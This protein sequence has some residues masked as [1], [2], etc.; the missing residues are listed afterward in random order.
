MSAPRTLW[1]IS[2]ATLT[3]FLD[4]C[5]G[6]TARGF[7]YEANADTLTIDLTGAH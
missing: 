3:Q 2:C 6:L 4:I 7:G 1:R 5:A